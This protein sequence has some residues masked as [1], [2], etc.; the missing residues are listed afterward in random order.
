MIEVK[1]I[2]LFVQF[3]ESLEA[4]MQIKTAR[5]HLE[6]LCRLSGSCNKVMKRS[7][8]NFSQGHKWVKDRPC[9][10]RIFRCSLME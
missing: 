3:S 4:L 8:D 2:L 7:R 10:N 5:F 1:L 9:R 6:S